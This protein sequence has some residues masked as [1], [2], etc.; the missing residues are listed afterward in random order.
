MHRRL[1]IAPVPSPEGVDAV[2]P[3]AM[4]LAQICKGLQLLNAL[5]DA[6]PCHSLDPVR[7]GLLNLRETMTA[8]AMRWSMDDADGGLR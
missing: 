5:L 4:E 1:P 2:E 3:P 7:A 8:E 6:D